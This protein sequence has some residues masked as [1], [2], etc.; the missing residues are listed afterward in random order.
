MPKMKT[1]KGAAKRFSVSKSGRVKFKRANRN[2][3]LT[4]N[5]QK[6]IRH[7]RRNGSLHPSDAKLAR[8]MLNVE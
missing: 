3:I 2:H 5:S 7:R 6:R 1:N 8:R 4:K